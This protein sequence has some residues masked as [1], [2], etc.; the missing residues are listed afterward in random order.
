M[1]EDRDVAVPDN[2]TI[3]VATD[4]VVVEKDEFFHLLICDE[5]VTT[6]E[7]RAHHIAMMTPENFWRWFRREN[8]RFGLR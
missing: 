3:K 6:G 2:V 7:R 8:R 5:D 1:A 4:I